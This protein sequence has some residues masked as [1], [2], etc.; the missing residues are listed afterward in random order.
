VV[1]R[2]ITWLNQNVENGKKIRIPSA[3]GLVCVGR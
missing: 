2:I 1:I 3:E